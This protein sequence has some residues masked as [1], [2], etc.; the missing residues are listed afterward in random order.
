MPLPLYTFNNTIPAATHSPA[1]DQPIMLANNVANAS[2]WLADHIGFNVN[3]SGYHQQVRMPQESLPA[4]VAGFGGVYCNSA[5]SSGASTETNLFYTPDASGNIYQLTRTVTG[6]FSQ[7]STNATYGSPPAGTTW[8]GGWTFLPGGM[9]LQYGTVN[10]NVSV[11]TVNFPIQFT[12]VPFSVQ[13][14][15][16]TSLVTAPIISTG[17]VGKSSFK[18]SQSASGTQI[19][20]WIAIGK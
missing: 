6:N 20:F 9:L 19:F 11:V 1:S 15:I 3:G 4:V 12:N 5:T 8:T 2:I 14:T 18:V 16:N 10:P 7:F 13:A 17:S